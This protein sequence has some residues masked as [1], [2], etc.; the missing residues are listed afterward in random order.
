M[1]YLDCCL[2]VPPLIHHIITFHNSGRGY[3]NRPVCVRV[4][5]HFHSWTDW[6]TVTKF[7]TSLIQCLC[8]S[9]HWGQNDFWVKRLYSAACVKHVTGPFSD[10]QKLFYLTCGSLWQMV[11]PSWWFFSHDNIT[12]QEL[13]ILSTIIWGS[14]P[15]FRNNLNF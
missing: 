12:I 2:T 4:C 1:Q 7:C 9:I 10:M 3:K 5:R 8:M 6:C 15:A 14:V 13:S 11:L